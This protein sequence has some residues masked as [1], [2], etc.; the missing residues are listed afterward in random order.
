MLKKAS[1]KDIQFYEKVIYEMQDIVMQNLKSQRLYLTGDTALS[2]FYYNHRYSEDLDFFFDG[3]HFSKE[4][5]NLDYREIIYR[6]EHQVDKLDIASEAEYFKR[7]FVYRNNIPLKVEL[8]YENLKTIGEKK[9]YQNIL[10]DSKENICANKITTIT[11]R[12]TTKDFFDLYFLLK[13]ISLEQA[14]KWGE[15]KQVPLDYEGMILAVGDILSNCNLLEGEV[16][17]KTPIS[18]QEFKDFIID[19]IKRLISYAKNR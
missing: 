6:L 2:R 12:K 9:N 18:E 15:Y 8:I 11:D 7:I 1:D 10:I 3:L 14:M 17:T 4:D 19:L 13:E 5:F 16:L